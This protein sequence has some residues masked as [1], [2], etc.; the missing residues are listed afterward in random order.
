MRSGRHW[1]VLGDHGV[2]AVHRFSLMDMMERVS[3]KESG[4][5]GAA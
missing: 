5:Y 2:F 3:H 1:I 4:I